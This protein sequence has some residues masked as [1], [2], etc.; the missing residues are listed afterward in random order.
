MLNK[1]LFGGESGLS[2]AANAGLALLRI[3]A[4]IAMAFGH[5]AGKLPPGEGLIARTAQMGFPMPTFFA[6]AAAISEFGGGIFLALGFLTRVSSFFIAVTMLVAL[7]GVHG[8]DPFAAQ[9]KAFLYLFIA[10]A[11]VIKGSGDWSI[12][13]YLRKEGTAGI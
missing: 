8:S 13:S 10:L 1:I 3:F 4:G 2:F 12:D 9:E 7:I 5:G 11:F 6:W